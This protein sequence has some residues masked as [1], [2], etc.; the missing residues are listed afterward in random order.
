MANTHMFKAAAALLMVSVAGSVVL[1]QGAAGS[2][3]AASGMGSS[4][5][6]SGAGGSS[7]SGSSALSTAERNF[8]M[9]AGTDGMFELE[10]ARMAADQSKD[11]AV[12]RYASMLVEQHMAANQELASL[13][14][15]KGVSL[16]SS[17]PSGK[18]RELERIKRAQGEEFDALFVQTVGIRDH[19][20]DVNRFREISRTAKDA[21][22]KAW[23]NKMLPILERH[24]SEARSLPAAKRPLIKTPESTP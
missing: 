15:S 13:A 17:V 22:V 20:G 6:G 4:T 8:L 19:R 11:D 9:R 10:A 18:R 23:A 7:S 21:D 14:Q 2:G 12:K 5:A 24:M 3:A 16:P 1:A